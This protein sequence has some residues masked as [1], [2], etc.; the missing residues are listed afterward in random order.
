MDLAVL[1]AGSGASRMRTM[2]AAPTPS[3]SS[4]R[5][6]GPYSGLVS[7][8]VHDRALLRLDV[9]HAGADGEELG[10]DRDGDAAAVAI[11]EMIDQVIADQ[12]PAA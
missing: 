2:S 7:A 8:C 10:G 6:C 9:G 12:R 5:P 4:L 3:R 11:T 1:A